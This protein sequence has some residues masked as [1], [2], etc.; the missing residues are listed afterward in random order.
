V[1]DWSSDVCSSDLLGW[2]AL[3]VYYGLSTRTRIP[4]I[5]LQPDKRKAPVLSVVRVAHREGKPKTQ[6]QS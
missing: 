2:I 5:D 6:C 1:R 4:I 3:F